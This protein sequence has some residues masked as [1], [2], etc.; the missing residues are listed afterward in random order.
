MP[1]TIEGKASAEKLRIGIVVA[2]FNSFITEKLLEGALGT[3]RRHGGGDDNI[4]VAYVPGSF[5]LGVTAKR[6]AETGRYDAVICI[7]CIIQGATGHYDCVVDGTTRGVTQAGLDTGVPVIF[8]VLTVETL[9]QAIERSGSKMGNAGAS[10]AASAIEMS[11][12][13]R[14]VTAGDA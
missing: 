10:A 2:R 7:G 12:V 14:E 11:H 13:I 1:R 3:I 4:T 8:G 9:E 6:M 5:E